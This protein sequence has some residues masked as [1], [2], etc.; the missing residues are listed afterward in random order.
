MFHK[1]GSVIIISWC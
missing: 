1:S